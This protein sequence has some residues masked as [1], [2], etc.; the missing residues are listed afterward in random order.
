[1]KKSKEIVSSPVISIQEGQEVGI[2]KELIVNAEKKGVEFLLVEK[3]EGA[4]EGEIMAIPFRETVGVGDYAVTIESQSALMDL[5]K[6]NIA[7]NL[8]DKKVEIIDE[9]VITK[10]GKLLGKI[11]EYTIDAESGSIPLIHIVSEENSGEEKDI[12][13]EEIISIGQQLVIVTEESIKYVENKQEA[14]QE[15][16]VSVEKKEVPV[17]SVMPFE[18]TSEAETE[19][20][21]TEQEIQNTGSSVEMFINKQKQYLLGKELK[22]DLKDIEGNLLAEEGTVISEELFEQ[23]QEMGRQKVIELTMLT[24]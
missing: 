18:S 15:A 10:K 14:V 20:S 17:E 7:G 21:D 8:L 13:L 12:P 24:E 5:S 19:V 16:Q 22:R 9:K 4:R 1:M 3:S 11:V 2:V 6:M 23:V